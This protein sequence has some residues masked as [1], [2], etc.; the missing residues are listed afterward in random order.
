MHWTTDDFLAEERVI[1]G[2]DSRVRGGIKPR[3]RPIPFMRHAS[4]I[5]YHLIPEDCR[6]RGQRSGLLQY[7]IV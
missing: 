1:M 6:M 4:R 7:V 3:E 2:K 5:N